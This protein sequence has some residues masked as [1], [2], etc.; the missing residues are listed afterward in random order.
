MGEL[1]PYD[2]FLLYTI[3][4]NILQSMIYINGNFIIVEIVKM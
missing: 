3:I 4:L 1:F 2:D